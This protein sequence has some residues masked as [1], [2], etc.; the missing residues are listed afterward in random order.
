M[1]DRR[2]EELVDGC[3]QRALHKPLIELVGMEYIRDCYE[4]C[5]NRDNELLPKEFALLSILYKGQ[6]KGIENLIVEIEY[7][8]KCIRSLELDNEAFR[9][10]LEETDDW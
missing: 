8:A 6:Q 4:D 7:L 2:I 5:Y 9:E 3:V 1:I 10:A